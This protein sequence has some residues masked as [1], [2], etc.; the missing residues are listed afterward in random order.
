M[1]IPKILDNDPVYEKCPF[2]DDCDLVVAYL[3]GYEKGK[4]DYLKPPLDE[5]ARKAVEDGD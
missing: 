2:G 4:S 1:N 5:T 3:A